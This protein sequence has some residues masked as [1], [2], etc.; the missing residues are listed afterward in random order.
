MA[1]SPRQQIQ[2][3]CCFAVGLTVVALALL[4]LNVAGAGKTTQKQSQIIVPK[5]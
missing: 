4:V 3:G 2:G 5:A 1:R